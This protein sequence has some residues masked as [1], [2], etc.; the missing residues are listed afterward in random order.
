ML[1][2][3]EDKTKEDDADFEL[4]KIAKALT[5]SYKPLKQVREELGLDSDRENPIREK[6]QKAEKGSKSDR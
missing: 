3:I 4:A 2:A 5:V 6:A 1:K